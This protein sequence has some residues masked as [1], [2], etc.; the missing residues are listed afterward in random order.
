M[1]HKK[2]KDLVVKIRKIVRMGKTYYIQ[3][4]HEFMEK[5]GLKKGD[6]LPILADHI[7]KVVPMQEL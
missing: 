7:M 5:H 1:K 2:Q 4:P 6:K 3:V